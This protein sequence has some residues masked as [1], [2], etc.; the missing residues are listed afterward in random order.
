M[1]VINENVATLSNAEVFQLLEG[2]K[3]IEHKSTNVATIAYETI[4]HLEKTPCRYQD[5]ETI[6]EF[7]RALQRYDFTKAE[8]LQLLNLRPTSVVEM[9][10]IIEELDER[11]KTEEELEKL[12]E[13]IEE[14]LP[15]PD[16][17][18]DGGDGG[19]GQ[20]DG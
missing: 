18:D 13:L 19:G 11:L 16:N 3:L 2:E 4:K 20:D 7:L 17:E 5:T 10:L 6:Q 14:K 1:E 8:K 12:V 15:V 9:Q